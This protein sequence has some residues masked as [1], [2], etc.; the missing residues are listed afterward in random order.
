MANRDDLARRGA[1]LKAHAEAACTRSRML[2]AQYRDL[3]KAVAATEDRVAETMDR[4]AA[5]QPERARRCRAYS[6]QAREQAALWRQRAGRLA[7][8]QDPNGGT[9]LP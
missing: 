7:Q 1:T 8:D 9:R 4:V 3:T 5:Q 6:Q 2:L